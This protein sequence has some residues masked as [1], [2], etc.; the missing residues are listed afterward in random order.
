MKK[1]GIFLALLSLGLFILIF[2][3][4][5]QLVQAFSSIRTPFLT[6]FFLGITFL[7]SEVIIFFFL[8]SMFLWSRKKHWILPLWVTLALSVIISL[9][10]KVSLRR[11]RPF[12]ASIVTTLT[13]LQKANMFL[14]N[15]STP[16]F[17]AML[18]FCALPLLIKEFKRFRYLW[19]LFATLV[20]LSRVY[21]GVHYLSDV[22]LGAF[23]GY[24]I[25]M[26]IIY[27]EEKYNCSKKI[28]NKILKKK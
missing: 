24:L 9:I 5:K 18:A 15:W 1:K 3:F 14:W 19:I 11:P 12:Q 27:L 13:V 7:S 10:M 20:A 25:G 22:I 8:T 2:I 17:Q 16:S 26:G 4:D 21:F 28:T 6:D 23:I